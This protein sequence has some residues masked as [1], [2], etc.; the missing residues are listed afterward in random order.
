MASILQCVT[1]SK[2]ETINA[3]QI[4]MSFF[5]YPTLMEICRRLVTHYFVLSVEEREMWE[6][7]PEGFGKYIALRFFYAN[8]YLTLF[9]EQ[10]IHAHISEFI[11]HP[12]YGLQLC[13]SD[14]YLLPCISG[15]YSL[16]LRYHHGSCPSVPFSLQYIEQM[17]SA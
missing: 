3:H 1:D 2:P 12:I 6:E 8:R 5:T 10:Q 14:G 17:K 15:R 7:D 13:F 16:C 4:K 11:T 9:V